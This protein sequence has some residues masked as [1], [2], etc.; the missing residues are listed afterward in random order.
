[1]QLNTIL[2]PGGGALGANALGG[3][4]ILARGRTGWVWLDLV[5]ADQPRELFAD[6]SEPVQAVAVLA[7]DRVAVAGADIRLFRLSNTGGVFSARMEARMETGAGLIGLAQ[8]GNFIVGEGDHAAPAVFSTQPA[9]SPRVIARRETPGRAHRVVLSGAKA[10]VADEQ[11]GLRV[12]DIS[13]PAAPVELSPFGDYRINDLLLEGSLA[14]V[15]DPTGGV[16]VVETGGSGI[17]A[18][19]GRSWGRSGNATG[20]SDAPGRLGVAGGVYGYLNYRRDAPGAFSFLGEAA[21][22]GERTV[23]VAEVGG[24]VALVVDE[25]TGLQ[26]I[27]V[28]DPAAP[29]L[30]GLAPFFRGNSL[31]IRGST[32]Y[33][34]CGEEG[35]R[36]VDVGDPSSPQLVSTLKT[37]DARGTASLNGPAEGLLLIADGVAGLGLADV[38]DPAN[39]RMV[40]RWRIGDGDGVESVALE[41]TV[42]IATLGS[43]GIAVLDLEPLFFPKTGVRANWFMYE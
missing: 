34:A 42:G 9:E 41:G 33:V 17:P 25:F 39:P 5:R 10:L 31:E 38:T 23:A 18:L 3:Q 12:F 13:N 11:G 27:D 16:L 21:T 15:S 1:Q 20:V 6:A 19:I 37:F 22:G 36:I 24:D 30:L 2:T 26:S 35:V 43:A 14:L 7:G 29:R 4:V 8:H 32:A 28:S 40:T